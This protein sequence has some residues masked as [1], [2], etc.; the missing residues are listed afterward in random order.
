MNRAVSDEALRKNLMERM[1]LPEEKAQ[2]QGCRA[3][4]GHCPVIGEQCATW[5]CVQEKGVEFCSD[6]ADFPCGK[7][8]PAADRADR[9][10]HNLKIYSLALRKAQGEAAW[11]KAIPGAWALYFGGKMV[12][13]RGPQKPS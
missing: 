2:C 7:L 11:E 3:I 9:L 13:G 5:L 4:E 8:L 6:C 10:P 1:N 12:I